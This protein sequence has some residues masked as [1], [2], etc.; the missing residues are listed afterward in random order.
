MVG[1]TKKNRHKG[2]SGSRAKSRTKPAPHI[3]ALSA[4]PAELVRK[5]EYKKAVP[6][7]QTRL[8]VRPNDP[9][10]RML[11][12][13]FL[14]LERYEDFTK[15]AHAIEQKDANDYGLLGWTYLHLK[16][17]DDAVQA[18]EAGLSIEETAEDLYW[19]GKALARDVYAWWLPE[20][21]QLKSKINDIL[22][23][24]TKLPNCREEAY[25]WHAQ[26]QGWDEEDIPTRWAILESGLS[27]HPEYNE[28]RCQLA[29]LAL[30]RRHDPENALTLVEPLLNVESPQTTALWYAYRAY[31]LL[32]EYEQA[33]K[34]IEAIPQSEMLLQDRSLFRGNALA[35]LGRYDEAIA[36]YG[37]LRQENDTETQVQGLLHIATARSKQNQAIDALEAVKEAVRLCLQTD[38]YWENAFRNDAFI[39]GDIRDG[40][41]FYDLVESLCVYL[42]AN[43]TDKSAE[44]QGW[45]TYLLYRARKESEGSNKAESG[46]LLEG[47]ADVDRTIW[48]GSPSVFD[49]LHWHYYDTDPAKTVWF[50]LEECM[51]T[52]TREPGSESPRFDYT[53]YDEDGEDKPRELNK[54][55]KLAVYKATLQHL[56]QCTNPE[57]IRAI[58]IPF[59][60]SFLEDVL[61]ESALHKE[62]AHIAGILLQA[63][64]ENTGLLFRHA[65]CLQ[66][67]KQTEE[68]ATSYRKLLAREPNNASALHNL[69]LLLKVQGKYKDA[70]DLATKA[71]SL[72]PNDT[73]ITNNLATLQRDLSS[74]QDKDGRK[75]N[76]LKTA[77]NR[78]S[79]LDWYKRRIL[80]TLTAISGF[81]G[82]DELA[83]LS[84]VKANSIPGHWHKLVELGMIIE[85]NGTFAVN[86]HIRAL[87]ERERSPNVVS[88]IIRASSNIAYKTIFY[89]EQEYKIYKLLVAQF[90]NQLVFPNMALQA[91]FEYKRMKELVA[92]DVFDYYLKASVDFCITSTETYLPIVA[93]E[94]DSP[95]H[96]APEQIERDTKKD[97]IFEAGGVPLVRL[98][99]YNWPSE[100]ALRQHIVEVLRDFWAAPRELLYNGKAYRE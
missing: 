33:L 19:L 66:E 37:V 32:K 60:D 86:E 5:G 74:E 67:L 80:A 89:S 99:A 20:H 97:Q 4:D 18:L 6:V 1:R 84:G 40:Y 36:E 17:W 2:G 76:F 16:Q 13:C 8:A 50:H 63:D 21:Q 15:V 92:R 88:R 26:L 69:S 95:V 59:Y 77:P 49:D 75:Q 94:V 70:A 31:I 47:L 82:W 62:N 52:F 72:A 25:L 38:F 68:A 85:E 12:Y 91:I 27:A 30:D 11:A 45:L 29:S 96:D 73:L 41:H 46:K 22:E 23:K 54:E 100:E 9:E 7:L 39:V 44:T 81:K 98:R 83:E 90:P 78:W 48:L 87:A 61:Q 57:A 51:A 65:Y 10:R 53:H 43:I 79:T 34:V 55:E 58:H 24:A 42:L 71:A 93:I 3:A 35:G 56:T 14:K 64:P 28:V